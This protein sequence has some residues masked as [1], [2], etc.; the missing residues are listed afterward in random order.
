[1]ERVALDMEYIRKKSLRLDI[2]IILKTISVLFS[3]NGA[4]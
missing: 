1:E 4:Y 2:K 3:G